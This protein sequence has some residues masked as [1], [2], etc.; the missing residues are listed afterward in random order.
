MKRKYILATIIIAL[1]TAVILVMLNERTLMI[2]Y[3]KN[4]RLYEYRKTVEIGPQQ[5]QEP[6]IERFEK[7][8][9]KLVELKYFSYEAI[10]LNYVE[11]PSEK[12]QIL[13]SDLNSSTSIE[14]GY[15]EICGYGE[16]PNEVRIWGSTKQIEVMKNIIAENEEEAAISE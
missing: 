16:D 4:R 1:V 10:P 14:E 7:Y 12:N 3:Y 9:E 8:Q 11:V 5:G 6:H 15:F 13:Y 2:G